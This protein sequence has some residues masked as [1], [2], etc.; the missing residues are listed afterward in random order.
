[1]KR[2]ADSAV[3][4]ELDRLRSM[5]IAELRALWRA[6]FRSDPPRAFGPDLMRRGI[7]YRI[8][9]AAYGGLDKVTARLL[10]QLMAQYTRTPGKL[11]LPRRI[12]LGAVLVRVLEG[13]KPSGDSPGGWLCL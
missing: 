9:E 3:E 11:V 7:A 1:M 10:D 6:K 8:Q 5:P 2:S 13:E 12:K 4:A